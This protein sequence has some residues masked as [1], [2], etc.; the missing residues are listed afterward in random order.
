MVHRHP[1]QLTHVGPN[2]CIPFLILILCFFDT[3]LLVLPKPD[4]WTK[5]FSVIFIL[6]LDAY[7][8]ELRCR[9][10]LRTLSTMDGTNSLTKLH[11][12]YA[13]CLQEVCP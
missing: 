2:A 6:G 1:N 13:S 8:D 12:A 9:N 5:A 4:G 10:D 11:F 7:K 3:F